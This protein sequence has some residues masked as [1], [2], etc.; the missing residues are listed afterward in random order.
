MRRGRPVVDLLEA[1]RFASN[2]RMAGLKLHASR[3]LAALYR[4][5]N[6][7]P[8]ALNAFFEGFEAFESIVQG[9]NDA[10][11]RDAWMRTRAAGELTVELEQFL[12]EVAKGRMEPLGIRPPEALRRLKDA[13]FDAE[14]SIG[15]VHREAQKRGESIRRILQIARALSSTAPVDE[16]LRQVVDG[17]IDFSGAE[18]AFIVLVDEKGRIRIPI[19]RDRDRE[20]V[21]SPE[22]Q[23]SR[24]IVDE[25]LRRGTS[26]RFDN[27][28]TEETLISAA[29]VANLELRSVMCAPLTSGTRVFGLLYVDNRSRTGHFGDVDLDLLDIFAVQVA[30]ALENARLVREFVRDEK[31]KVMGNLTRRRRPR[32][33]QPALGDPRPGPGAPR[34]GARRGARG[35]PPDDRDR[36]E[37]RSRHRAPPPGLHARP[38]RD[39]VLR[40]PGRRSRR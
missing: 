26:L 21:A 7:R 32:L 1:A 38:P 24:R 13:L 5:L 10:D 3:V 33:Q 17:V 19:A 6:E 36:G 2:G 4:E 25:V 29:S 28:M 31:L 8:R 34:E 40:P 12:S 22:T 18:R 39:L 20:A 9:F 14:R 23:I 37:G 30:I 11:L 16:L 35:G 15:P 27:A